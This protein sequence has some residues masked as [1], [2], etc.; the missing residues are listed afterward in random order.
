MNAITGVGSGGNAWSQKAPASTARGAE[1]FTS[2]DS[3]VRTQAQLD[4]NRGTTL[5]QSQFSNGSASTPQAP[6]RLPPPQALFSTGSSNNT[7]N[8]GINRI[9][10]GSTEVEVNPVDGT[11]ATNDTHTLSNLYDTADVD[12]NGSIDSREA[13]TMGRMIEAARAVQD[14][15]AFASPRASGNGNGI[16]NR[17]ATDETGSRQVDLREI[18]QQVLKSYQQVGGGTS[19]TGGV[20]GRTVD[21]LA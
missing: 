8:T 13:D 16:D 2:D 3:T 19:S 11:R 10:G 20:S 4:G 1:A 14:P 9:G 5:T 6:G 15:V 18:A 7:S 21:A 17:A 12:R